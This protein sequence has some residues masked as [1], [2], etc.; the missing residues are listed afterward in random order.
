MTNCSA[1]F[2]LGGIAF[3]CGA[4]NSQL[5]VPSSA[6][7]PHLRTWKA[8]LFPLAALSGHFLEN[9]WSISP[10]KGITQPTISWRRIKKYGGDIF[11]T[12]FLGAPMVVFYNPAGNRFLF[13]NEKKL[14]QISW[15]ASLAKLF[16]NSLLTKAGHEAKDV[17]KILLTFLKLEALQN[18]MGRTES[19]IHDHLTRYWVGNEQV[20]TFPL[21][22][23]CLFTV[24][25]ALFL[26]L[27]EGPQQAELYDHF[28]DM[29]NE[30]ATDSRGFAGNFVPQIQNR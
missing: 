29:L 26:S 25:C 30:N 4:Q 23:R 19:I 13:F 27:G 15:L 3:E 11:K 14:I 24:A 20:K 6:F 9:S 2:L 28:M 8:S 22:K 17:R 12:Q 7:S 1:S 16:G 21:V 10:L 5:L 18:F